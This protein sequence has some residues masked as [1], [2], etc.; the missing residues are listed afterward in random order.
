MAE[1]LIAARAKAIEQLESQA[2]LGCKAID[3]KAR[4]KK[5]TLARQHDQEKKALSAELDA[6]L[7]MK[8]VDLEKKKLELMEEMQD[9]AAATKVKLES[10]AAAIAADY[11]QHRAD[12]II[13]QLDLETVAKKC[14]AEVRAVAPRK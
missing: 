11:Y 2:K 12:T 4:T 10:R 13:D 7:R 3:E 8:E 9:E 1:E 14:V 6:K 5:E